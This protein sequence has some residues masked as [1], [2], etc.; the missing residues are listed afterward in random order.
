MPLSLT[1]WDDPAGFNTTWKWDTW[2]NANLGGGNRT[3][4]KI[5]IRDPN[6]SELAGGGG[7][8]VVAPMGGGA[9]MGGYTGGAGGG[10]VGSGGAGVAGYGGSS[11]QAFQT[12]A[13]AADPFAAQ[14][15]Q[16][17]TALQQLMTGGT[18]AI[19]ADPSFQQR[20]QGGQQ[21][22]E[23][24]QAAKG[25]LGSGNILTELLNYGQGQASQ[26]YQA[27]Y[28]R[29]AKLAG[30]DASSPGTAGNILAQIPGQGLRE[31]QAGFDQAVTAQKLPYELQ[32]LQQSGAKGTIEQ[33]LLEQ[34]IEEMQ[35]AQIKAQT[36]KNQYPIGFLA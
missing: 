33:Q 18:S 23:R 35:R 32:A 16:Y 25:F 5:K 31:Q 30:V 1:S 19:A 20:L 28:D 11:A 10:V 6:A 27:Q 7:G 36:S 21:A 9:V 3:P 13:G 2:A 34:Q 29:L 22:L 12:A 15:G 8:G 14:R 26:E 24:S 17:Q 4:G